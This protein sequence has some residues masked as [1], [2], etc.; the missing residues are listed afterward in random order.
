MHDNNWDELSLLKDLRPVIDPN[1]VKGSKNFLI[2]LMHWN[3]LRRH[4]GGSKNLLDFG[5]GIGRYCS[6]IRAHGINYS[7]IDASLGMIRKAKQIHK[8]V[9]F[10]H[11]DGKN[12]PFSSGSFDTVILSEVL[13]YLLGCDE[14]QDALKEIKRV[15]T[16][17][18]RLVMI[19]Q[20]S[21]SNRKSESANRIITEND[22]REALEEKFVIDQMYKV[23][24]PDFSDLTC[25]IID[26]PKVPLSIFRYMSGVIAQHESAL[27]KKAGDDHFKKTSYYEFLIEAHARKG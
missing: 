3:S 21:I 13:T 10:K 27:V 2:D 6:R 12:I 20:A 23:R 24:S 1:D 25:R 7:G 15:L 26:S 14:S 8:E 22:Y 17:G 9:F 16:P 4:L 11:Y 19:E 5:C 18:G